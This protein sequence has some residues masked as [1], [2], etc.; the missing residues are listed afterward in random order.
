MQV[1]FLACLAVLVLA[2]AVRAQA[3]PG[4]IDIHTG[5]CWDDKCVNQRCEEGRDGTG[6]CIHS[7]CPKADNSC[8]FCQ[9]EYVPINGECIKSK[10][11]CKTPC[12][13][14]ESR[15]LPDRTVCVECIEGYHVVGDL[16]VE[17]A[18]PPT[19]PPCSPHCIEDTEKNGACYCLKCETGWFA[20]DG[21]CVEACLVNRCSECV[22]LNN[23]FCKICNSPYTLTLDGQCKRDCGINHCIDCGG[24]ETKCDGE[25]EEDWEITNDGQCL[26]VCQVDHCIECLDERPHHCDVCEEGYGRDHNGQC[27]E[28]DTFCWDENCIICHEEYPAKCIADKSKPV[29]NNG[30]YCNSCLVGWSLLRCECVDTENECGPLCSDC[31]PSNVTES[32]FLCFQCDAGY[33]VDENGNCAVSMEQTA[34]IKKCDVQL[35][36]ECEPMKPNFCKKCVENKGPL[37]V[38]KEGKCVL[39]QH[40]DLH[41]SDSAEQKTK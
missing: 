38:S 39:E 3:K 17:I 13:K 41:A 35:C 10:Q 19:V 37:K 24:S 21:D 12:T 36:E 15:P 7:G 14:C 30:R 1:A 31:Q 9:S 11:H 25:C 40:I 5:I 6:Q 18:P 4:M 27:I 20:K 34:L 26:M 32:G 8:E 22:E 2:P 33:K 23:S 29:P 28:K 16:C